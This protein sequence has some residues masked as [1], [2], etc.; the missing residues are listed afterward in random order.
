MT[1]AYALR[2]PLFKIA[3][4]KLNNKKELKLLTLQIVLLKTESTWTKV[5]MQPL[6]ENNTSHNVGH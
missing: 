3:W 1:A 5:Q 2:T 4:L 6:E